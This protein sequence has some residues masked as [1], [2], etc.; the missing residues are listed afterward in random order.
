[1]AAVAGRAAPAVGARGARQPPGIGTAAT[2]R[3]AGGL[4]APEALRGPVGHRA[5]V[6]ASQRAQGPLPPPVG[7]RF[8][9]VLPVGLGRLL[10]GRGWLLRRLSPAAMGLEVPILAAATTAGRSRCT[11]AAAATAAATAA[12]GG[13]GP[14]LAAVSVA[15]AGL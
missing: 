4:A 11:F 12:L 15:A 14:L 7:L 10:V 9:L 8:A 2:S 13:L 1:M 3:R 6:P 5:F